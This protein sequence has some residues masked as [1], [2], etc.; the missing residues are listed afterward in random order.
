MSLQLNLRNG[1]RGLITKAGNGRICSGIFPKEKEPGCESNGDSSTT[2]KGSILGSGMTSGRLVTPLS[3]A[4]FAFILALAGAFYSNLTF[5]VNLK[6]SEFYLLVAKDSPLKKVTTEEV[7]KLYRR[8]TN[9]V[10]GQAY[11]PV[12][13]KFTD[14]TRKD[15][16]E[17]VLEWANVVREEE[18]LR[19]I[20]FRNERTVPIQVVS[21]DEMV[22]QVINGNA[23]GYVRAENIKG[24]PDGVRAIPIL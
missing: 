16:S 19:L 7:K 11:T 24:L 4:L 22:G 14:P 23:V 15:F 5:A 3:K 18:L 8:K 6:A 17:S 2:V 21:F 13:Y 9:E 20:K 12:H 1:D 10:Q